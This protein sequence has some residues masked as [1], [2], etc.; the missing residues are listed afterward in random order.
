MR[1]SPLLPVLFM[2]GAVLTACDHHVDGIA[3]MNEIPFGGA[4]E[5][6]LAAMVANPADL[7]RGHGQSWAGATSAVPPLERLTTDHPKPLLNPGQAGAGGGASAGGSAG[8][9]G[10]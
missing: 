8:G 5:A 10:G 9:A 2:M 1:V 6:N 3:R 4:A 7:Y